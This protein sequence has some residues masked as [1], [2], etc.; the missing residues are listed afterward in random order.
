MHD[1]NDSSC[2]DCAPL[3]G[4]SAAD[5]GTCAKTAR[6]P[7]GEPR[8]T[9]EV[10]SLGALRTA[11]RNAIEQPGQSEQRQAAAVVLREMEQLG[12]RVVGSAVGR[13]TNP[14]GGSV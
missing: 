6:N 13:P 4:S 11:Q 10:P 8:P 1:G 14:F 5:D 2:A 3:S 9:Y 12:R 7:G